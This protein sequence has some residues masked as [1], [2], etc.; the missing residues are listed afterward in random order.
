VS[1]KLEQKQAR[2]EAEERRA[3]EQ[4]KAA[5]K[6]NALTIGAALLVTAIVVV[7]IW[8]Q[9]KEAE[10]PGG[11]ANLGVA[12]EQAGCG[13]IETFEEQEAAHIG[14]DEEHEPY[15]SSPPT[16]GPHYEIPA[17]SA[18]YPDQLPVE[19][20]IHNQEHGMIVIWY[21]PNASEETKGQIEGLVDQ[22]PAATV[23]APYTDIEAPYQFV[24]SA[25]GA[26]QR[27]ERVS[28]DVV[29]DFRREY[30]G[31]GPELIA[32]PFEG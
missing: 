23:A 12:P 8:S 25:W 18:F 22:E 17:D 1:K 10:A 6:R 27:C 15:N 26:L 9:K 28:Q 19:Q 31:K 32:P 13:E 20:L 4:K 14:L 24:L 7:A 16:S 21:S 30:Q 5:F 2:R 3:A 11:E 29:D